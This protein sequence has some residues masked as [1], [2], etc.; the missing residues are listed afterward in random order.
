MTGGLGREKMMEGLSL[1][2]QVLLDKE[3]L[4]LQKLKINP[5]IKIRIFRTIIMKSRKSSL[6]SNLKSRIIQWEQI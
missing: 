3:I 6:K 1:E 2:M 5:L 4:P